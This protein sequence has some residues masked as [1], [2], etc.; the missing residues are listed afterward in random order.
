MHASAVWSS[1]R[2]TFCICCVVGLFCAKKGGKLPP[3][4]SAVRRYLTFAFLNFSTFKCKGCGLD[5]V[6]EMRVRLSSKTIFA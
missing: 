1:R 6:L 5:L 2:A 3:R 4:R